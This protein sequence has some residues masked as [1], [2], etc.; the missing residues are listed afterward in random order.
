MTKAAALLGGYPVG[1]VCAA[2]QGLLPFG[3]GAGGRAAAAPKATDHTAVVRDTL[4]VDLFG[5]A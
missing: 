4:T 3:R 2:A 5:G 1:P